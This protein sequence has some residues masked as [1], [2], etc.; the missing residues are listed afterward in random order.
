MKKL[1]QILTLLLISVSFNSCTDDLEV[2]P[3]DPLRLDEE[4][5][6]SQPGAYSSA[7]AGVYANLSLTSTNGA[8]SSNLGGIDAGFSQ[9]GRVVWYLNNLTTD[10]V[11]WS[12]EGGNDIGVR[13]LQR[14][15]WDASNPF[16][17]GMYSRGMLQVALAN[18]FLRQSTTDKLK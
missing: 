15:I 2:D 13:E 1:S 5:F 14:N 12:Y 11:I 8:T 10:E 18:E 9:Y 6:Y 3:N 16:F 4:A 7:I 17:R